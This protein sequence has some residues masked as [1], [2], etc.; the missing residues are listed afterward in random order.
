MNTNRSAQGTATTEH[1]QS[2]ARDRSAV[3]LSLYVTELALALARPLGCT[4]YTHGACVGTHVRSRSDRRRGAPMLFIR[5]TRYHRA[6]SPHFR[7]MP[8]WASATL[9]DKL[10]FHLGGDA[11]RASRC[12]LPNIQINKL[13][14]SVNECFYVY[15]TAF[16]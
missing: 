4:H 12:R 8:G 3:V 14:I 1:N 5:A 11:R 10:S 9:S 15:R 6:R 16:Q 13:L 2:N 7:R